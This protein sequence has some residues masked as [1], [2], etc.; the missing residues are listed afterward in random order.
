MDDLKAF[1]ELSA[2]LTGL[3]E[4]NSGQDAPLREPVAAEY[5]RRIRGVFPEK[6]DSLIAL[7]KKFASETPKPAIDDELLARLRREQVFRDTE[8]VS[9]QI[10]NI[11]Y[12]SQF[13]PSDDPK[14]PLFDGGYYELGAV[15]PLIKAHPI[16]FSD[17]RTGYWSDP[18]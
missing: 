12:F 10:V 1:M 4:I 18:P 8:V 16:G 5:A 2:L 14:A 13:K 15:W 3:Y 6:F 7:Y 9:R 17:E 11:W